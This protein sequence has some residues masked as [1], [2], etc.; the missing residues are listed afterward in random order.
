M[1]EDV[2]SALDET[3]LAILQALVKNARITLSKMS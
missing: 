3:D 1:T 2:D